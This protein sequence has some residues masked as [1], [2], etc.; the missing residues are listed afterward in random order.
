MVRE[1][2]KYRHT[3]MYTHVHTHLHTHT[4]THTHTNTHRH[5]YTHTHTH[6]YTHTYTYTYTP[7]PFLRTSSAPIGMI[8]LIEKIKLCTYLNKKIIKML[9]S[10]FCNLRMTWL[11]LCIPSSN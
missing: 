8:V 1:H 2:D 9:E 10:Q 4:H 5:T 11:E 7:D 6:T 3:H